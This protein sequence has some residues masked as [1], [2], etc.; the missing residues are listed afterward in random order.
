[1]RLHE[2]LNCVRS[3]RE[4]LKEMT[5][6]IRTTLSA[7]ILAAGAG[8]AAMALADI[9][10]Y[11]TTV[12]PPQVVNVIPS[13]G[14]GY[15]YG[16]GYYAWDGTQYVWIGNSMASADDAY[17]R[18]SWVPDDFVNQPERFLRPKDREAG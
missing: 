3:Y 4:I 18:W 12:T 16:P 2:P 6:K 5:M 17:G 13:H 11:D 9:Y 7:L 1:L 15:A 10:V 8:T 14:F